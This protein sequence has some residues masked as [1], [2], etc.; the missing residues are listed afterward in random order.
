M[1][2]QMAKTV[3]IEKRELLVAYQIE[4]KRTY[5]DTAS[6]FGVGKATVSRHIKLK[7]ETGKSFAKATRR[8]SWQENI[9]KLFLGNWCAPTLYPGRYLERDSE[10]P[11]RLHWC[12]VL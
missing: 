5:G 7:R 11:T 12:K 1:E 4:K 10:S 2:I 9:G 8:L 6:T 3:S